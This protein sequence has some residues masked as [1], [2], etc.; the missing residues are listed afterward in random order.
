MTLTINIPDE[1]ARSLSL[2]NT[3]GERA[4]LE[5][6]AVEGYRQRRMSRREV[7]E[8]LGLNYY[9]TETFLQDHDLDLGLTVEDVE[10]DRRN[11]DRLLNTP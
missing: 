8:L 1:V 5:S 10:Q 7:G 4:V 3:S 11:L 9:E 6:L 2:D